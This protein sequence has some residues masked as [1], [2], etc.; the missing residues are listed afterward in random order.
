[1]AQLSAVITTSDQEF[2][3]AITALLRSSGLSIGLI[4]EKHAAGTWLDLAVVD[5]RSGSHL[6]IEAIERF[7]ASWP[8]TSIFAIAAS[9]DPDQILRAMRAGANEF[10]AMSP[11]DGGAGMADS[12]QTALRRTAERG[13]PA[14]DNTRT[15]HTFSFFGAKGGSGTT[16]LA[17]NTA[18]D[19]ARLSKRPTLIID[20]HQFVGEV[21]LFLG[22]RPRFT[23]ID[24]LDNL[25]RIDQ[26]FL[27]ELVVRHRTGLDIL[28]GGDQVDRPG[29]H[30]AAAVEQLLQLLGRTY[31]FVVV[32]A[33]SVASPVA[34]VAVFSAD[35]IYLVANPDIASIR[36]AH[37]MMDRFEQLGASK[38]RIRVLLN[39]MSDQ[40]QIGP[41]QIETT[42]G[43][44]LHMMFPSDYS[45]V[46]AAMN[47]GV[48]LTLTNHSELAA[49]FEQL[50]KQIINPGASAKSEEPVRER[51]SFLGLF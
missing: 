31:D 33:G 16:T 8:S 48:P 45:V 44:S 21:A 13:R 17:V 9:T 50:T 18:V 11:H 35:T 3:S 27:R 4:D 43:H 34:D 47:S 42:L 15:G 29:L 10:L 25:H 46:S 40:H 24:A 6:A 36:N 32:D 26:D 2:R 37:R 5:I 39:R 22:V 41:K 49:R 7:R 1:M 28:A 30:D 14:K 12:F 20:L 38:E 23:L 51:A 19:I